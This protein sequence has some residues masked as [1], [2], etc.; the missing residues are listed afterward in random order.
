MGYL[1][2]KII[3]GQKKVYWIVSK[4]EGKKS[5]GSGNVKK[6]EYYLGEKTCLS[7]YS[8]DEEKCYFAYSYVYLSWYVWNNDLKL[9]EFVYK[10]VCFEIK[11]MAYG[12]KL[13][14]TLT[15]QNKVFFSKKN[16]AK[17]DLRKSYYKNHRERITEKIE[18]IIKIVQYIP[19]MTNKI[20][21][22]LEY[23]NDSIQKAKKV[24]KKTDI[25]TYAHHEYFANTYYEEALS[26]L[27]K[28]LEYVPRTQ[29]QEAKEK[30]WKYCLTKCPLQQ[31]DL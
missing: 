18:E 3:N 29:R 8:L 7:F 17:I 13:N 12:D 16:N 26:L 31:L 6:I 24:N 10:F 22:L 30:I 27:E 20:I 23:F 25:D 9:D 11:Y 21:K 14:F 4:R 2:E 19:S 5:G 15:K 28:I 1:R